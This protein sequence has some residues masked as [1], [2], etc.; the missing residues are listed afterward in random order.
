MSL[1]CSFRVSLAL[2]CRRALATKPSNSLCTTQSSCSETI[3][4]ST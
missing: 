4:R 1:R 3:K 2:V